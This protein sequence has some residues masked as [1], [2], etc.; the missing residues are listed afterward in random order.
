M[1][2]LLDPVFMIITTAACVGILWRAEAAM[3]EAAKA[4]AAN[5]VSFVVRLAFWTLCVGSAAEI[6]CMAFYGRVPSI[7]EVLAFVGVAELL[8]P[9]RSVGKL[10]EIRRRHRLR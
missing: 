6:A 8:I 7:Q 9:G 10:L 3:V 1:I 4:G 2:H 5:R